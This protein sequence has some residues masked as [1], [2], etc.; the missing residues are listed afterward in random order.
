MFLVFVDCFLALCV[1]DYCTVHWVL[2]GIVQYKDVF[3]LLLLHV[4]VYPKRFYYFYFIPFP[5][6]EN[7]KG[8]EFIYWYLSCINIYHFSFAV[9]FFY[10]TDYILSLVPRFMLMLLFTKISNNWCNFHCFSHL[11][12]SVFTHSFV[13]PFVQSN[14]FHNKLS[15]ILDMVSSTSV[16]KSSPVDGSA[17]DSSDQVFGMQ[18]PDLF[19]Y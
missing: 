19:V 10:C 7:V 1:C 12:I 16:K 6:Y 18:F 5:I 13:C 11:F 14:H 3:L 9:F 15:E 17:S 2:V 8:H 4:W